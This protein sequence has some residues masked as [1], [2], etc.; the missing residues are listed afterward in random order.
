M[1]DK[2]MA[3]RKAQRAARL[4]KQRNRRI[5][6]TV[7]LVLVV[8]V[9]TISGTIAWLTDSTS[10]ITNTFSPSDIDIELTETFNTDTNED[11]KNDS[12][13]AK[14][15]P[16]TQITKDPVVTVAKGSEDCWVFVKLE[17]DFG[18]LSGLLT[19][20]MGAGYDEGGE[21]VW[22]WQEL[23]SKN[24]P[25]VYYVEYSADL[26]KMEYQVLEN[27]VVDCS[28]AI[29][30]DLLAQLNSNPTLKIT[31]Y[32]IQK[33]GFEEAMGTISPQVQAWCEVSGDK[34]PSEA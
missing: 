11:G 23:D 4:R 12:W 22:E 14:V 8:C 10:T 20:S 17:K 31:A 21:L 26:G 6:V 32:A 28:S 18:I 24:Y 13:T 16:G 25:G 30:K 33:A 7:A 9:A 3:R 2:N 1:T 29:T 34:L 5:A 15:V 27:N 19:Y